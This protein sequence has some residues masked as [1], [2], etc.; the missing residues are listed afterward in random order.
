MTTGVYIARNVDGAVLYVGSTTDIARR[1][2]THVSQSEWWGEVSGEVEQIP[3]P[4]RAA[5]YD[6]ERAKILELQPIHN[7]VGTHRPK[8]ASRQ[9]P[10][11]PVVKPRLEGWA[12]VI[13]EYGNESA[14]AKALGADRQTLSNVKRGVYYPS[15]KMIAALMAL[16]GRPFDDLF[17]VDVADHAKASA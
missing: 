11:T 2:G 4:T 10:L 15:S 6:V 16:T 9:A 12:D 1:L 17:L 3:T 7:R 14:L 5:A 8:C 13:T